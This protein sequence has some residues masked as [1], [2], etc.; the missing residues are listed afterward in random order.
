MGGASSQC[1]NTVGSYTCI[2]LRG[3]TQSDI[4]VSKYTSTHGH[5]DTCMH[6]CMHTYIHTERDV[7]PW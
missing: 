6:A 2:S 1:I 4:G 5:I 7:A 3:D